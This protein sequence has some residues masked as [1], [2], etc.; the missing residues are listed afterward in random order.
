MIEFLSAV[1][2]YSSVIL[3]LRGREEV[4][5]TVSEGEGIMLCLRGTGDSEG[6]IML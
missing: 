6:V 3:C 4:Y 2:C 1:Q 5:N